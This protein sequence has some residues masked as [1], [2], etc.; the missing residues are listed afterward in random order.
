MKKLG[1][2]VTIRTGY[3]FRGAIDRVDDG[4]CPLVQMGDVRADA[5][6]VPDVQTRVRLPDGAGKHELHY[7]DVLFIARGNRNE[8]ATFCGA[9]DNTIATP[10]LFVLTPKESVSFGEYLTWYLNLPETQ[11]KI[12]AM[13]M[14]SALPF[15][16]MAALSQLDVP[17]PPVKVQESIIALQGLV[18]AE[19]VLL[20]EIGER[21]KTLVDAAALD[22]I[23]RSMTSQQS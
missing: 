13:R 23:K 5:G 19:Q 20:E 12:R 1:E 15:V 11:T 10:H 9:E 7:G 16:P 3:P 6:V 22:A 18:L 8:A 4:N 21:R 14:G 2:I 17:V